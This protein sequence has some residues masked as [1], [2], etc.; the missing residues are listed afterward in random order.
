MITGMIYPVNTIYGAIGV[1]WYNSSIEYS[2]SYHD[3]GLNDYRKQP[4]GWHFGAGVEIP[5][6]EAKNPPGAVLTTD[7]RYG[8][9]NYNFTEV[10]GSK[11]INSDY[12]VVTVGLL[13][14][15]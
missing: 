10:P 6:T 4:F 9:L 11:D 14:G 12:F 2:S 15:I 7:F 5:L 8:F 3:A 13:F 1:G